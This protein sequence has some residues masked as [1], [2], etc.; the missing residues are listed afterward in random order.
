MVMSDNE[1]LVTTSWDDGHELD[2]RLAGLLDRHGVAGTFY[3]APRYAS[4]GFK[5]V[6]A[7]A[8]RSIAERFEIGGHTLTHPHLPRVHPD[9]AAREIADGK[10]AVEDMIGK[11][12]SS[13]AYPYGEYDQDHVSMVQAAGYTAA[14]TTRRYTVEMGV[15]RF[16]MPTSVHAAR[17]RRDL[18]R[19]LRQQPGPAGWRRW[20]NWDLLAQ[21]LFDQVSEVGGMFHLWGHSWEIEAHGD[22]DRL[23]RFLA[24]AS[25]RENVRFV[26]NGLLAETARPL[27]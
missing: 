1:V 9:A 10:R 5:H 22:W 3:V 18:P 27:R 20:R 2:E 11:E 19:L 26:T 21:W 17:Y 4:D 14:R 7:P 25:R 6:R 13:F 8:L 15:R 16:E 12:I 23:D 24:H